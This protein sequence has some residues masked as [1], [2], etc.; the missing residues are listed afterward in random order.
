MILDISQCVANAGFLD[1]VTSD[2]GLPPSGGG[3]GQTTT[4][5]ATPT[6]FTTIYHSA[7]D[8]EQYPASTVYGDIRAVGSRYVA[9]LLFRGHVLMS[10]VWWN[11]VHGLDGLHAAVH[12]CE[13]SEWWS[14]CE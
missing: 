3:G 4:S 8:Y 6:T 12:V 14:Q 1:S 5:T 13:N 2:P 11:R 7:N 10:V 9:S